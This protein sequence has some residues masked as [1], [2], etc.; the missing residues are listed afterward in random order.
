MKPYSITISLISCISLYTSSN[1]KTNANIQKAF[2]KKYISAKAVC[3]GGLSIDYSLTNLLKDT[4]YIKI[5]AGWRFNSNDPKNDYQDILV[6]NE[7]MIVLKPLEKKMIEINGY[8]CEASKSGPIKGIRYTVGKQADSSLTKLANYLNI[9]SF[10]KNTIQYSVWAISDNNE[11]AN[12]TSS[13]DSITEQLRH[14]VALLKG[15]PLPWYT[16][17]KK[18][19]ISPSGT[20]TDIPL[21][22]KANLTYQINETMYSYCYIIDAKGQKVSDMLGKWILPEQNNYE[23]IFNI[24]GL[25]KGDYKLVLEGLNNTVFERDFKI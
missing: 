13:N 18:S 17:L 12:I 23:A 24:K 15:E 5:P 2:D 8:C 25:K 14:F 21:K 6:T 19:H 1:A 22:F 10:D 3:R 7:Q 11:T 9:N 4:L 16:L 20:I